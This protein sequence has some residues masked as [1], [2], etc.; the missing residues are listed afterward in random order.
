MQRITNL[1]DSD[2][3][4]ENVQKKS[5]TKLTF[6]DSSDDELDNEDKN[7]KNGEEDNFDVSDLGLSLEQKIRKK[8]H[9]IPDVPN[10]NNIKKK[11]NKKKKE[12]VK[13]K[14]I[15]P[16]FQEV[17]WEKN[18]KESQ[19]E[20]DK[21]EGPLGI[22][23]KVGKVVQNCSGSNSVSVSSD[24]DDEWDRRISTIHYKKPTSGTFSFLA[25]LS[26]NTF[27]IHYL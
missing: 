3:S 24:D 25:S 4:S 5:K 23:D 7:V 19:V 20:I 27:Y 10:T 6:D 18:C 14:A 16:S 15:K 26:S 2:T 22:D 11:S 8:I 17:P 12:S 9:K 1:C 21:K 13:L